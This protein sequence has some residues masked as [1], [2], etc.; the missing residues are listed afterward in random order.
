[1]QTQ[2]NASLRELEYLVNDEMKDR[3]VPNDHPSLSDDLQTL[4]CA[5][6]YATVVKRVLLLFPV[7]GSFMAGGFLE[8]QVLKALQ[9]GC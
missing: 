4:P 3:R 9:E 1:M 8:V 5:I 7:P 6:I 2:R